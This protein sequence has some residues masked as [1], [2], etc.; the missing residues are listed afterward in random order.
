MTRGED[1]KMPS[2]RGSDGREG[3]QVI[4]DSVDTTCSPVS[5]SKTTGHRCKQLSK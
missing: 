5:H 1:D 4:N 2:A 3:I